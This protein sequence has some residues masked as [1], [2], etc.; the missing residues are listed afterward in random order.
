[1]IGQPAGWAQLAAS[2]A[3]SIRLA[4][5]SIRL[6]QNRGRPRREATRQAQAVTTRI[7]ARA[8]SPMVCNARSAK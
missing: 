6:S 3:A 7:S 8:P 2:R 1:M 4:G 5:N